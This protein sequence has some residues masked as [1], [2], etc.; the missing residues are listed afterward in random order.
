MRQRL[1]KSF[2]LCAGI[3]AFVGAAWGAEVGSPPNGVKLTKYIIGVAD[4]EKTYAFYHALGIEIAGSKA[5]NPAAPLPDMIRKLVDV[6]AGT[7]FRNAM[8]TI[9]GADF[10]LEVTEFTNLQLH[11]GRP[12]AFDPGASLLILTVRDIDAAL[13]AAKKAGA[14]VATEGGAAL[15]IGPNNATRAIFVRDPDGFYVEF[16]QPNPLPATSAPAGANVIGARFGSVVA[17]AEKAAQFYHDQFGLEAKVNPWTSNE[18]LLKLSGLTSGQLRNATVTVPG[19]ALAWSFFEFK[20]SGATP[21]RLRIPDPGAPAIGFQVRDLGAATALIKSAGGS[22][23]TTGDG[24][25]ATPAGDA[26]TF[27]RDPNGILVEFAQNA[28]KK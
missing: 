19:T 11:P 20:T 18:G 21:Y 12:R 5:L 15:G 28:V 7:K 16:L 6:P 2:L 1:S 23:I 17:D 3:G 14:E 26:V 9:P 8:L 24:R 25:L 10:A 4:L 27:A 22:V 13:T